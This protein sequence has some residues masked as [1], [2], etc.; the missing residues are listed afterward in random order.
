LSYGDGFARLA[1]QNLGAEPSPS[2]RGGLVGHGWVGL[3]LM[4]ETSGVF[5]AP[6]SVWMISDSRL[7]EEITP[8]TLVEQV[9]CC[10]TAGVF[11]AMG[12]IGGQKSPVCSVV[13]GDHLLSGSG[14]GCHLLAK[15]G[16]NDGTRPRRA[17]L[18]LSDG[19]VRV[20]CLVS[21]VL[22]T[23][24]VP[25]R[26]TV[27]QGDRLGTCCGG[28]KGTVVSPAGKRFTPAQ[29]TGSRNTPVRFPARRWG[30]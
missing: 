8:G 17:V 24:H 18:G 29:S 23:Q 12:M 5:S 6:K 3:A 13:G 10:P 2:V 4:G 1:G 26:K 15:R 21:A 19:W 20:A 16:L 30:G 28:D 22:L 11:P 9:V 14:V 7:G 27:G 25:A